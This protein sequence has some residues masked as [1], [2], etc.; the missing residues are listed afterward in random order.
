MR[1]A[2]G[3]AYWTPCKFSRRRPDVVFGLIV[4]GIFIVTVAL[5]FYAAWQQ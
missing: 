2:K 1:K 3:A 5:A 4:L